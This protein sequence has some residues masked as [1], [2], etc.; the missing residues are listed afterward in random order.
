MKTS[1]KGNSKLIC[2]CHGPNS[3]KSCPWYFRLEQQ[4]TSPSRRFTVTRLRHKGICQHPSIDTLRLVIREMCVARRPMQSLSISREGGPLEEDTAVSFSFYTEFH[5]LSLWKK[6]VTV[7][8][9]SELILHQ[10]PRG[11]GKNGR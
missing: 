10:A 6:E 11:T 2:D 3:A 4:R 8:H 9:N 1:I 5:L 7:I